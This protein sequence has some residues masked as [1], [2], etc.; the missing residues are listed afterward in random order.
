MEEE[1]IPNGPA[2]TIFLKEV[3]T[4]DCAVFDPSRG[5]VGQSWY[6][7][8]EVHG[9]L[10]SN[11]FVYDFGKLKKLI[12]QTAKSSIDHALLIP[13]GSQRVNFSQ[14]ADG[15]IWDLSSSARAQEISKWKYQCPTGAVFPIRSVHLKTSIVEAEF[16]KLLRHRLPS[17]ILGVKTKLREEVADPTEAFFRYTHGIQCHDG[18]CQRLFHGHKSRIEIYVGDERRPDLE[19]FICRELFGT[20]IHIA[21]PAQIKSGSIEP[22][23][24]GTEKQE[25]R[26]EY[27]ASQGRFE[28]ILPAER[29]F[30]VQDETSIECIAKELAGVVR[31]RIGGMERIQVRCYEGI[32]KG[33][34]AII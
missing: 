26:L 34:V 10:D 2:E 21:S 22:G 30:V 9:A 32:N 8:A 1:F 27:T 14:G 23:T 31:E 17:S 4:V 28:A 24:R 11:H 19:H 5:I 33:A 3:I 16:N 18:L 6:L 29:V 12:R 25:V 20:E 7:D 13:V 15:E